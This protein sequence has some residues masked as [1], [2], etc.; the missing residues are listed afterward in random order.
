MHRLRHVNCPDA[1]GPPETPFSHAVVAGDYAFLSG[2]L[3]AD[4]L[5]GNIDFGN[6]ESE[7]GAAMDLLGR[8]L[9]Q[10]DLDYGDIV[11]VTV[12]MT[13]LSQIEAMNAVYKT[14]FDPRRLP[15][16]TCVGVSQLI[17]EAMIEIDCIA[18]VRRT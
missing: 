4:S 13:D 16:R 8:V 14:Y 6:I 7:T 2:C 3:A 17:A 5:H 9:A 15:A 11:R 1:A 12:F 10:L 18:R